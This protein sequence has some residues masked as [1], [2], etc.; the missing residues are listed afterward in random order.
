M[1]TITINLN[2]ANAARKGIDA[3]YE[4]LTLSTGFAQGIADKEFRTSFVVGKIAGILKMKDVADACTVY[5]KAG[6]LSRKTDEND[7]DWKT[8]QAKRKAAIKAGTIEERTDAEAIAEVAA[9]RAFSRFCADHTVTPENEKRGKPGA[10]KKETGAD[11]TPAANNAKTADSFIRQQCAMLTAYGEKNR[12][13]LSHAML[14]A[15]A[16]F[17]EAVQAVQTQD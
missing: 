3:D 5:A 16:E 11:A 8:R 14:S 13:M 10:N 17:N 4:L 1:K 15:I 2:V 12:A 9:R 7:A 6:K